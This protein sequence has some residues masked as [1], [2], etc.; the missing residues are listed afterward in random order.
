MRTRG[1]EQRGPARD[2]GSGE[3][4][5]G[6]ALALQI[7][8]LASHEELR[9]VEQIQRDVW[10][11]DDLEIVPSSHLRAALHAGGQ[12]AGAF[13]SGALVGFSYGFV[14][15]PH[16]PGMR[17]PG[18]HSHMAAVRAEARGHGVGQ[19]LKWQQRRWCLERGLRWI[20]WTFDPLQARNA[21]LNLRHLGAV[22]VEYLRD[23]YGP[24]GGPLGGGQASDRLLALWL[25]DDPQ[26]ER[27]ARAP[28]E[29]ASAGR[30]PSEASQVG[31]ADAA[32]LGPDPLWA[33]T[34]SRG[35]EPVVECSSGELGRAA[36]EGRRVLVAAPRDAAYLLGEAPALAQTWRAALGGAVV[37]LV[38]AG[39]AVVDFDGGAYVLEPFRAYWQASGYNL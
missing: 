3:G 18:L 7:K 23:F 38:Q 17:G 27:L 29:G 16:G 32:D 36:E 4:A 28:R 1:D 21:K 34:A 8:P 39:Y 37:P 9:Q 2:G 13:L 10:G 12:L 26:V 11:L 35:G 22:A 30:A 15:L 25:L 6:A 19:A 24:M 31:A 20:T 14:A 33:V 5:P